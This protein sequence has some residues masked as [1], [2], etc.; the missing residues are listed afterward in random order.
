MARKKGTQ[1]SWKSGDISGSQITLG[2]NN[3]IIRGNR[4]QVK[5]T[6]S[7]GISRA[8]LKV[9]LSEFSS[10][11]QQIEVTV[12]PEKKA[13]ALRKADELQAAVLDKKPNP[14]QMASI[15]DWFVKNAP[16]I[17]GGVTSL[18]VNPIV[19]KLVEAA[20]DA[21]AGQFRRHFGNAD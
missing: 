12:P 14:S 13:A 19:G 21:V 1:L 11:K 15:R 3:V 20:G 6:K 16:G 2:D 5:Q 17:A 18:V 4:N 9:L 8:E 7:S 10:L